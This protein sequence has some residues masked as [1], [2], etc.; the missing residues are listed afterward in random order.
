VGRRIT[1][2]ILDMRRFK[3]VGEKGIVLF[4]MRQEVQNPLHGRA[5]QGA[6]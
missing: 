4:Y 2:L 5:D 6:G 3:I 1:G